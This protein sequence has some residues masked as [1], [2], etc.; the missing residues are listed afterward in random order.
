MS[1][2]GYVFL[3]PDG[4]SYV[5]ETGVTTTKER[6]PNPSLGWSPISPCGIG[7]WKGELN[8]EKCGEL[9][10]NLNVAGIASVGE[11]L[12]VVGIA[13]VGGNLNVAGIASVGG[14]LTVAGI[15]TLGLSP[16]ATA[17]KFN[18][19]MSFELLNNDE[20]TIRAKCSDGATRTGAVTF[21]KIVNGVGI[22]YTGVTVGT[23]ATILDFRGS[24]ISAITVESGVA[25]I[26]I[27]G[28]PTVTNDTT[29]NQELYP[30]FTN[31]TSGSII[32]STGISTSKLTYNPSTGTLTATAFSG[33]LK[34]L[35]QNTQTSAYILVADD[36]GKNVAIT[37]GGVTLNTGVFDVGDTVSVY[38]DSAY[39]QMINVGAGVSMRRVSIGDTGNRGLNQY[40]LATI[41]C[42]RNDEFIISGEGLT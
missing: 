31:T 41:M 35:P 13:S 1:D 32:N 20:I 12:N 40:G 3:L 38:N 23:G 18:Y 8:I 25:T 11:N 10:G 15:S 28:G 26:D 2:Y 22:E 14:N 37:T 27:T 42:I 16:V 5:S 6:L 39:T 4:G 9:G 30:I 24:G 17:P 36:A 7:S 33:A 19:T 21:E 29:T 34:G